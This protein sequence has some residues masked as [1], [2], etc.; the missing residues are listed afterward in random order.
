MLWRG[1][2]PLE[3]GKWVVYHLGDF[4]VYLAVVPV[5]VVP[6]VL[7]EL[8][9][10]GRAGSPVAA[11][12]VAL[13]VSANTS[14]L[15]IVAAFTSTPWGFDRLHDRYGFYLLPLW[16]D[17][18]V[19]WLAA[20]LPRP[21][22][23]TALGVV[24]ALAAAAGAPVPSAGERGGHRHR[25]RRVL[26]ADRGRAA[27]PGPASGRFALGL[28][29]VGLMPATLL[30]PRAAA[31][32]ALPLAVAGT[33]AAMSYFAWQR[34]IEA[35]EDRVFAGGLERPGSTMRRGQ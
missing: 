32:V 23:A 15:L 35:P 5:A 27:G 21:L 18:P 11:A 19:V 24:A 33:L 29:V 17:R 3:V 6:I 7:W 26:G 22:L 30:L 12:F 16:L 28:F 10:A 34:L 9:R 14:G 8:G 1:Y 31:R 25:P 4:A 2:D 13:F 20:G